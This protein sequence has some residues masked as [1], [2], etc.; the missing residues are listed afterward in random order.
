[1]DQEVPIS[2]VAAFLTSAYPPAVKSIEKH[3]EVHT[4]ASQYGVVPPHAAP[5]TQAP[6]VQTCVVVVAPGLQR[7]A[8]SVHTLHAPAEH[9]PLSVPVLHAVPSARLPMPQLP[10]VQVACKHGLS[11]AVH[12][13][14]AVHCTQVT[15]VGSQ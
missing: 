4:P 5:S 2:S 8:P 12:C 14:A 3:L 15:E 9:V 10:P 1:M 11:G 7:F 6:P 13:E